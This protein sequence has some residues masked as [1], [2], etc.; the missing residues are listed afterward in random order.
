MLENIVTMDETM[1]CHHI[2]E[3]KKQSMQWSKKGSQASKGKSPC[4]PDQAD[5]VGVF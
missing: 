2:P 1:G 4:Q 5:A 3:T